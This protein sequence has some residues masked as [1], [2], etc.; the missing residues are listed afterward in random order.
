[1]IID[2]IKTVESSNNQYAFR[3]EEQ[4]YFQH[5]SIKSKLSKVLKIVKMLNNCSDATA[6]MIISTSWGLF[7]ILGINVYGMCGYEKSIIDF[8][9]SKDDQEKVFNTFCAFQ[10]INLEETEKDLIKIASLYIEIEKQVQSKMHLIIELENELTDKRDNYENLINFICHYNG[11]KFLS[12]AF[13]D[14]LLRMIN[15]A[16]KYIRR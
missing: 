16:K 15:E 12:N 13:T 7:Q 6:L 4:L 3:F 11:A 8:F 2:V 10:K 9:H 14:Y 5:R 1:M